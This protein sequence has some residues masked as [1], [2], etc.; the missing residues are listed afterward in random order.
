MTSRNQNHKGKRE[1]KRKNTITVEDAAAEVVE[2]RE[3][4]LEGLVE[5]IEMKDL[6][7]RE[8]VGKTEMNIKRIK[9]TVMDTLTLSIPSM[10]KDTTRRKI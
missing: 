6:K 10:V 7:L 3:A 9:T 1:K 8:A 4:V 5:V 2:V